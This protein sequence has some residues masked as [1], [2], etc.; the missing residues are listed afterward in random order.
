MYRRAIGAAAAVLLSVA[1]A[2][3]QVPAPAAGPGAS[4]VPAG[5]V[6][7]PRDA[8]GHPILAGLWNGPNPNAPRNIARRGA[9]FF[10]FIGRGGD[11][12]GFEED[13]GLL[14]HD[15]PDLPVYKPEFWDD[16]AE[17]DYWGN[18]RDITLNHCMPHG[19][20][21]WRAPALIQAIKDEPVL[22]MAYAGMG[23]TAN[24]WRQV[25][26]NGGAH[27]DARVSLETYAGDP[28]GRWEGDTLVIESIG[29]TDATWLLK[30]GYMHGYQMKVTERFTRV[31]NALTWE[32]TVEDPEYLDEPFEMPPMT[33]Y[34]NTAPNAFLAESLPCDSRIQ[35]PWG[36]E[37]M[38]AVGASPTRS[39]DD[40]LVPPV[41]HDWPGHTFPRDQDWYL[42]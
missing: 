9:D 8:E 36:T 35:E 41:G 17:N 5:A 12:E 40:Q 2:A 29:F 27:N 23:Q 33:V 3:A 24:A 6:E 20:P 21:R 42:R 18:W 10:D 25:P 15:Y 37:D 30:N 22:F 7:M 31:G 26:T 28:V 4:P 38:P 13:G 34:L 39:G 14:Y 32:A 16:V 19:I 1:V 11:F